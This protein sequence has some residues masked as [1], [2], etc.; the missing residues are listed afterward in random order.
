MSGGHFDYQQYH[1]EDIADSIER[2]IE[3]ATKPKPPLV[4]REDVTVFR[5]IDDWHSVGI[6]KGFKTY[7]EAVRHLKKDKAY[8]FICEYEKNGRRIAEFMEGDKQIE[9]REL[10]YQEYED[11]EYYPEYTDETIQIFSDAVKA[12]RKAAIYA[13]R[14]DWLLSGDDGEESLK[15]RLEEELKK[16]EEES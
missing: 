3:E 1:I 6:Y 16:L 5:K 10:K 11:G 4:W 13:N 2:E 15:E 14:I 9:V 8:K 12:L 7:D